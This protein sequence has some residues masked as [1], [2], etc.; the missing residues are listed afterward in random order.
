MGWAVSNQSSK[1]SDMNATAVAADLAKGVFQL[2]V[3]DSHWKIIETDRLA[4][5]NTSGSFT[6]AGC[7]DWRTGDADSMSAPPSEVHNRCRI[8]GCNRF[9]RSPS[10]SVSLVSRERVHI[11]R[12][13]HRFHCGGI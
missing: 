6:L 11:G 10:Y 2:A 5:D 9:P 7:N 3:A 1:D 4:A 13:R 12:V 8:Y